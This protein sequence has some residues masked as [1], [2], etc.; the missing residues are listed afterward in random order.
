MNSQASRIVTTGR[1]LNK[2]ETGQIV[3]QQAPGSRLFGPHETKRSRDRNRHPQTRLSHA[4]LPERKVLRE[5]HLDIFRPG[6]WRYRPRFLS[7]DR[8]QDPHCLLLERFG[9]VRGGGDEGGLL[10]WR[11]EDLPRLAPGKVQT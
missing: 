3:W 4:K 5:R 2:G 1:P 7:P 11:I 9:I 8:V 10:F 6:T